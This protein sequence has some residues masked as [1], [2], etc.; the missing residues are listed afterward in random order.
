MDDTQVKKKLLFILG[1]CFL[2]PAVQ[3]AE[4][5]LYAELS[6]IGGYSNVDGWTG[7]RSTTK[8]AAGVEY[9]RKF[10]NDFGD[11]WTMDLQVRLG[12]DTL[13][14]DGN[15]WGVEV[16]NAWLERKLGLGE[17]IR[18]GHFDPAFGLEPALDT[19]G[20]LLQTLAHANIGYK[21]DWGIGYR[22]MVGD[23]DLETA[24]QIGSGMGLRWRDGSYLFSTRLSRTTSND[25]EYG[26]SFLQGRTLNS[27]ESWTIPQ[28]ELLSGKSIT[29]TRIGID[30][31]V[32]FRAFRLFGEAA[33]GQNEGKMAAGGMAQIEYTLPNLDSITIKMQGQYWMDQSLLNE[34][35][36]LILTPVVE[37]V[38]SSRSTVR[39]GYFHDFSALDGNEDRMIVLNFYYYG[40]GVG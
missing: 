7:N 33:F 15:T 28:P 14:D 19:H 6:L 35:R 3:A 17:S 9:F 37:Y 24:L 36:Q 29:K 1:I 30:A 5:R 40:L 11:T 34:N 31:Q 18:F 32:P 38:I 16:H 10:S 22:R 13:A 23:Y 20:S 12:Y 21:K 39:L 8:N 26:I 2:T 25:L 4:G 27:R